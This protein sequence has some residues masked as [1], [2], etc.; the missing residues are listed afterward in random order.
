MSEKCP[1]DHRRVLQEVIFVP[2][3]RE[4]ADDRAES[5]FRRSAVPVWKAVLTAPSEASIDGQAG[6]KYPLLT[7]TDRP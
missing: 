1:N 6:H 7:V 4:I 3:C 5:A 2:S